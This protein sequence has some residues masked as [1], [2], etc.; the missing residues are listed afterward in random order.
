MKKYFELAEIQ[1]KKIFL[2]IFFLIILGLLEIFSLGALIPILQLVLDEKAFLDS[3]YFETINNYTSF[4]LLY[5]SE[6]FLYFFLIAFFLVIF[7]KNLGMVLLTHLNNIN[8]IGIE[9]KLSIN[10]FKKY[11]SSSLIFLSQK[12]S[13]EIIRNVINQS[14]I[15]ANNFIFSLILIVT[16][17]F[18]FSIIVVFLL[19]I[20]P[21]ETLYSLLIFISLS[22]FYILFFKN[23]VIKLSESTENSF[24]RRVRFLNYGIES[25]KEIKLYDLKDQFV[26]DYFKN[27]YKLMRNLKIVSII[28]ILPRHLFEVIAVFLLTIFIVISIQNELLGDILISKIAVFAYAGFRILPSLNRTLTSINRLKSSIPIV[29]NITNEFKKLGQ[30]EVDINTNSSVEKIVLDDFNKF[31]LKELDF[32]YPDTDNNV[33]KK[34]NLSIEKNSSN[35][36][37]GESGSGKTTLVEIIIG[38][39]NVNQKILINNYD[40]NDVKNQWQSIISYVPQDIFLMDDTLK[41]NIIGNIN[42]EHRKKDYE[43][44]INFSG[45]KNLEETL[46]ND[47][48][49]EKGKK[50]SSGQIKRIGIARAIYK[51][52]AKILIFDEVTANLDNHSENEIMEKIIKLSQKFTII[53]ISHN[54]N[55]SKYFNNVL[56]LENKTITRINVK[57]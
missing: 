44:A 16:E 18:T 34:L 42:L 48:I 43:N 41:N 50:L 47:T 2:M 13:S 25:V 28:R 32:K 17:I 10:L 7:L 5:D 1:K 27:S 49:G 33:F 38:L 9:T 56:K 23:T 29:Q 55:L 39:I 15:Y 22:T 14:S 57:Q 24:E 36:I 52:N 12:R 51:K 40:L 53:F 31:E 11:I 46:K 54:M 3:Q 35:F 4:F 30:F 37:F 19:F 26:N 6:K 20:Y 8:I 21:K 45:L